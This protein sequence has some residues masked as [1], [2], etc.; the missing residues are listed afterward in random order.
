MYIGDLVK[1]KN[2]IDNNAKW[3]QQYKGLEGT[4]IDCQKGLGRTTSQF[5]R[6]FFK[7]ANTYEDLA[8]W[9]VKKVKKA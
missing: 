1:L 9:R 6:V 3:L 2:I 4:I 7:K 5:V 8:A